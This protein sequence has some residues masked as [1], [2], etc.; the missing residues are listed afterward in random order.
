MHH[1]KIVINFSMMVVMTFFVRLMLCWILL[2]PP[3]VLSQEEILVVPPTFEKALR[4]FQCTQSND[5]PSDQE[6]QEG[7]KCLERFLNYLP[8]KDATPNSSPWSWYYMNN[9][10]EAK[11]YTEIIDRFVHYSVRE[12]LYPNLNPKVA[13]LFAIA[14]SRRGYAPLLFEGTSAFEQIGFTKDLDFCKAIE[15]SS[16]G[17]PEKRLLFL[18]IFPYQPLLWQNILK[19]FSDEKEGRENFKQEIEKIKTQK[20]VNFSLSHWLCLFIEK[21]V[22]FR[23]E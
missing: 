18:S 8:E 2:F 7:L 13:D 1:A 19:N 12:Q 17:F 20:P 6:W 14:S 21:H 15:E 16:L 23:E 3:F 9:V 11:N 10:L 4:L 5:L 22:V